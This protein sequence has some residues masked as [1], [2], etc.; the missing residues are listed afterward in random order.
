MD[1]DN[2]KLFFEKQ[3]FAVRLI[4]QEVAFIKEN[5]DELFDGDTLINPRTAFIGLCEKALI[6]ISKTKESLPVDKQLIDELTKELG[7]LKGK[8]NE[9]ISEFNSCIELKTFLEKK[10]AEANAQIETL[11]KQTEVTPEL[12]VL[13]QENIRLQAEIEKNKVFEIGN[14]QRLLNLN[15]LE[16]FI[17]RQ[18]EQK[19]ETDA[20]GILI[21]R[22]FNVYQERG[23]GDFD[24]L[25]IAPGKMKEIKALY[26]PKQ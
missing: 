5:F 6:K 1:N 7:E 4:E 20:K 2:K 17:L 26:T 14:D 16:S 24:I 3:P 13:Q 18:I 9:V 8:H 15:P 21:D 12:Q 23:N 10:L 11:G 19:H 22:F 25:R